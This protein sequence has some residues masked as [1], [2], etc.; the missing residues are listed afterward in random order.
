MSDMFGFIV[1]TTHSTV[2]LG[3]AMV[4]GKQ[5]RERHENDFYATNDPDAVHALMAFIGDSIEGWSVMKGRPVEFH[6]PA[7]GDGAIS[8]IIEGYGYPCLSTDLIYRGYGTGGMDFTKA[9]ET[10]PFVITNPPFFL[11]EEFIRKAL[12][13]GA[14]RV[15]M[16]LK[17]QFF[18]ASGRTP[19]FN[20][21][22]ISRIMPLNWRLDFTGEGS[23]TMEC[24][25]YEWSKGYVGEPI[26]GPILS[27]P[28]KDD[29]IC[30]NTI[31]LFNN[32]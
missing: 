32:E 27:R 15:W 3:V 26:Y 28:K 25:W 31:D 6:E 20:D 4:G 16:L 7:C 22:P 19:L 2:S 14:E 12:E 9:T 1:P 23:P 13:L 29:G 11:A 21:T 5:K 17:S 8:R 24:C 30:K 18:H 10:K